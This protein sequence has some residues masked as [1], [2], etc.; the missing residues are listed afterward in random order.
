MPTMTEFRSPLRILAIADIHGVVSVYEWLVELVDEYQVDLLLIAGDLFA[1]DW[2][3]GQ[4][5][6]ALQIIPRL[7]RVAAPCFYIMGNDDNVALELEDEQIKPLHGRRLSC[8]TYNVVGYQYTP[9]FMGKLFVKS[10]EEIDEDLQSLEPLLEKPTIL[11]TH[12]PAYGVLDRSYDGEHVGSRALGALLH[13]RPV[14]VHIHGHT[15]GDF[16]RDENHFNVAAA[17]RRRAVVIDLPSLDHQLVQA[18]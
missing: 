4:R 2:E 11:V 8:G 15:H 1:A 7:K 5:E 13:R 10:E 3:D 9:P 18:E 14:L 16:G 6:Q 17:G 12:A